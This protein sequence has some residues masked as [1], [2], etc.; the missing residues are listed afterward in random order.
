[1]VSYLFNNALKLIGKI[2]SFPVAEEEILMY[3]AQYISVFDRRSC[4]SLLKCEKFKD[5]ESVASSL[6]KTV[7]LEIE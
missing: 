4:L 6:Q 5:F 2:P 7:S 1:M 3:Q